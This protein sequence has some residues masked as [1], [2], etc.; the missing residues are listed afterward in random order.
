M[1][2]QTSKQLTKFGISGITAAS[3]DFLVYY[4]ASGVMPTMAAKAMGFVVGTYVTYNLNKYWTWRKK[5]KSRL[6]VAK[7]LGLYAI[8]MVINVMVN[9]YSLSIIPNNEFLLMMRPESNEMK[10]LFALKLDKVFAFGI[11]T[12]VSSVVNFLGQKFWVFGGREMPSE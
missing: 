5:D 7:F 6:M 8:S 11:A 1:I 4:A 10:E 12:A 2:Y 3:I 9:E